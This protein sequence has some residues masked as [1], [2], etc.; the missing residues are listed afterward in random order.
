MHIMLDSPYYCVVDLIMQE[1]E[2][3]AG[4]EIVDKSKQRELFLQ[5]E[6]ADAF[7][8]QIEHLSIQQ[9]DLDDLEAFLQAYKPWMSNS[10]T[11]H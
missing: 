9:P 10:L 5:G 6:A 4:I 2:P 8:T 7:R 3:S 11:L 1:G